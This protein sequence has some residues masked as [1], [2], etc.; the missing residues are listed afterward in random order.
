MR[1]VN[2]LTGAKQ[3]NLAGEKEVNH[4]RGEIKKGPGEWGEEKGSP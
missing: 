4:S 2:S 1:K 3:K